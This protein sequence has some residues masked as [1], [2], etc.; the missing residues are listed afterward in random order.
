MS[1]VIRVSFTLEDIGCWISPNGETIDVYHPMSTHEQVA[2][3]IL[4][5]QSEDR[6]INKLIRQGWIRVTKGTTFG[7]KRFGPRQ[8]AL[9]KDLIRKNMFLYK[10]SVIELQSFRKW[11][12]VPVAEFLDS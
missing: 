3:N 1:N 7:A 10:D 4:G 8:K 9:I 2:K 5:D 11:L 12:S 6:P